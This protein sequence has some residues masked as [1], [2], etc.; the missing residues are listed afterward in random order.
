MKMNATARGGSIRSSIHPY[1]LKL[2]HRTVASFRCGEHKM[3]NST[4]N[5]LVLSGVKDGEACGLSVVSEF[6]SPWT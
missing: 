3:V 1:F 5:L 6:K 4:L 2:E